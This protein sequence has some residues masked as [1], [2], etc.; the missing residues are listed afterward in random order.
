DAR[1]LLL[2]VFRRGRRRGVGDVDAAVLV[3]PAVHLLRHRARGGEKCSQNNEAHHA[4]IIPLCLSRASTRGSRPRKARNDSA[5]GRLPP[6]ARI[7]SR[8]RAPVFSSRTPFSS[9]NEYASAE[10]TSAHL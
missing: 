7:S 10:R 4:A 1:V 3:G 5:A 8:K 2:H 9:K 6:T